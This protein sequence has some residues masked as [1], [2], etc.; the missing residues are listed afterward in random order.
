MPRVSSFL[1]RSGSA[2]DELSG[3]KCGKWESA[4]AL[5]SESELQ[6]RK[7][8]ARIMGLLSQKVVRQKV[9]GFLLGVGYL[10]AT[11][12]HRYQGLATKSKKRVSIMIMGKSDL[13]ASSKRSFRRQDTSERSPLRSEAL[14]KRTSRASLMSPVLKHTASDRKIQMMV[15]NIC[16]VRKG[17][18]ISSVRPVLSKK[19]S[20]ISE[21]SRPSKKGAELT[22]P[23]ENRHSLAKKPQSRPRSMSS[24]ITEVY[25]EDKSG[26]VAANHTE[27]TRIAPAGPLLTLKQSSNQKQVLAEAPA[28]F[29]GPQQPA[30]L[31]IHRPFRGEGVHRSIVLSKHERLVSR[32]THYLKFPPVHLSTALQTQKSISTPKATISS[33]KKECST[34]ETNQQEWLATEKKRRIVCFER[35][36]SEPTVVT[37]KLKL[38][39]LMSKGVVSSEA[40]ALSRRE[41]MTERR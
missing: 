2:R 28:R 40:V 24:E 31:L 1:M 18:E 5:L 13:E 39:D 32:K 7:W 3:G 35:K 14:D 25:N 23:G 20:L 17:I 9:H 8:K 6:Q 11:R 37:R 41:S 38:K 4:R 10:L 21:G 16:K 29:F 33:V 34:Q 27:R 22:E 30:S 36:C 19:N 15:Y 12:H 26:V